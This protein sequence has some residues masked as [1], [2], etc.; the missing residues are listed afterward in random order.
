MQTHERTA[1]HTT[2]MTPAGP[3]SA[4]ATFSS[5]QLEAL[6]GESILPLVP[7]RFAGEPELTA[8]DSRSTL[9]VIE[10]CQELNAT[11]LTHALAN[12]GEWIRFSRAELAQFY[13]AGPEQ[14]T[15]DLSDFLSSRPRSSAVASSRRIRLIILCSTAAPKA[16]D[17]LEFLRNTGAAIEIITY[18]P[19]QLGSQQPGLIEHERVPEQPVVGEIHP[20]QQETP[21]AGVQTLGARAAST[22]VRSPVAP[23]SQSDPI[24]VGPLPTG[25]ATG[26]PAARPGRLRPYAPSARS[27]PSSTGSSVHA[28]AHEGPRLRSRVIREE[29]TDTHQIDLSKTSRGQSGSMYAAAM[30]YDVPAQSVPLVED[31]ASAPVGDKPQM[32]QSVAMHPKPVGPRSEL[33][34]DLAGRLPAPTTLVW[35]R[36]RRGERHEATLDL[37]GVITLTDGSQYADPDAAAAGAAGTD[38]QVDG[39]RTWRLGDDGPSLIELSAQSHP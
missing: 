38:A 7:A 27:L 36:L 23:V 4:P 31:S 28:A 35:T 29:A 15:S 8:L 21:G 24:P 11:S 19:E 39:W 32:S 3:R 6:L 30:A 13:Q 18:T 25:I 34:A 20:T 10:V 1:E 22:V 16:L 14:F 26:P 12:A 2:Q 5:Q 37:T 9:M 17:A 33:L